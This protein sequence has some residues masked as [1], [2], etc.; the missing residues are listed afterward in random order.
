MADTS[1]LEA[2]S[3]LPSLVQQE[4]KKRVHGGAEEGT[5]VGSEEKG[6]RVSRRRLLLNKIRRRRIKKL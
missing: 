4:G 5:A 6:R 3:G 1:P 2:R